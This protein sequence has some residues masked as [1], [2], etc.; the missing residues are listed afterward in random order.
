MRL[1][2]SPSIAGRSEARRGSKRGRDS[3]REEPTKPRHSPQR[4]GATTGKSHERG[5][6]PTRAEEKPK[7]TTKAQTADESHPQAEPP[8]RAQPPV[9]GRAR[10]PKGAGAKRHGRHHGRGGRRE[11]RKKPKTTKKAFSAGAK[12]TPSQPPSLRQPST[13]VGGTYKYPHSINPR[14]YY[15]M[16]FCIY[17]FHP[18]IIMPT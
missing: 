9:G 5:E 10:Q 18:C 13:A 14:I 2:C 15:T 6:K 4:T 1:S 3:G 16:S 7:R 12:I 17:N 11:E 8:P